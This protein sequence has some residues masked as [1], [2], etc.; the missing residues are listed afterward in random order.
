VTKTERDKLVKVVAWGKALLAA[1]AVLAEPEPEQPEPVDV[2]AWRTSLRNQ[3]L[4]G[5]G[6]KAALL[7][8]LSTEPTVSDAEVDK[9]LG[10]GMA[11]ERDRLRLEALALEVDTNPEPVEPE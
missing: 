6:E 7:G 11:A 4:A 1:D 5:S 8:T 2:L 9:A 10:A 3:V